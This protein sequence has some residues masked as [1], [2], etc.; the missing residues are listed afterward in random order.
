MLFLTGGPKYLDSSCKKGLRIVVEIIR[1]QGNLDN[2]GRSSREN[3]TIILVD[4]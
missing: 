2:K 3:G 4:L 1:G